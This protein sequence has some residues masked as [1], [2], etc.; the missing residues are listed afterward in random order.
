MELVDKVGSASFKESSALLFVRRFPL[1]CPSRIVI[2]KFPLNLYNGYPFDLFLLDCTILK[3][4]AGCGYF[5]RRLTTIQNYIILKPA[6][7]ACSLPCRLTT[8]QNY[9]ILKHALRHRRK[10]KRLITIQD[11]TILKPPCAV[12]K[13]RFGLTTIQDYTILKR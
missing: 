5:C 9:I 2:Y 3:R 11:Y 13:S 6:F 7:S 8:I 1:C 12:E 4:S 10:S